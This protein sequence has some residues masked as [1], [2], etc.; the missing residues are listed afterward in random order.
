ALR[1]A[2]DTTTPAA[3]DGEAPVSAPTRGVVEIRGTWNGGRRTVRIHYTPAQAFAAGAALIACA[4]ITETHTGP[5]P[6]VFA[7]PPFPTPA[8]DSDTSDQGTRA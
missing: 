8:P 7:F 2:L 6:V 5:E 4:A 3:P 1:R